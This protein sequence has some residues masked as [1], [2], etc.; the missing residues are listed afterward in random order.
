MDKMIILGALKLRKGS[1]NMQIAVFGNLYGE[2][3]D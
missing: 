2:A 1:I 3:L